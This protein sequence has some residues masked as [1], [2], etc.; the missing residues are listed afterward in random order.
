MEK[1]EKEK[2]KE[3]VEIKKSK[4]RK[5]DDK[6]L[7]KMRKLLY[8]IETIAVVIIAIIMLILITNKT[9]FRE[10]YRTNN[11]KIDI[12][13][14]TFFVS[15]KNDEIKLL[16]L[17]KSEYVKKYFE[18]YLSLLDR[19]SCNGEIFYYDENYGTAIYNIDV[20]KGFALKTIT[21]KY[22]NKD[23]RELCEG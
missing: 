4:K 2:E 7:K 10:E 12:P 19:Y 18:D 8:V 6:Q 1:E 5:R 20:D 17:R 22:T 21:I 23:A 15:D 16:T 13:L 9:F 11:I 3:E 14:L